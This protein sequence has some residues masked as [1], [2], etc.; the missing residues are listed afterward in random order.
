M[1][2]TNAFHYSLRWLYKSIA[3]L[4][5]TFAVLLS[6]I[7]LFLPYADN[8][9]DEIKHYVN[10]NYNANIEIESLASDWNNTGPTFSGRNISFLSANGTQAFLGEFTIEINLWQSLHQLQLVTQNVKVID[11]TITLDAKIFNKTTHNRK[12]NAL[13][14]RLYNLVLNQ[15]PH[16]IL[17]NS[18]IEIQGESVEH[19]LQIPK[20]SWLNTNTRHQANGEVIVDGLS[21]NTLTLLVDLETDKSNTLSGQAYFEAANINITP[22]IKSFL[23]IEDKQ[24]NS[25]INFKTWLDI[26]ENV[27]TQL[28]VIFGEN[29]LSWQSEQFIQPSSKNTKTT[30]LDNT[31]NQLVVEQGQVVIK[32]LPNNQGY[33]YYTSPILWQVNEQVQQNLEIDGTI[34]KGYVDGYIS[35]IDIHSVSELA[36]LF[37]KS[38]K[39][40]EILTTLSPR[41]VVNE[42]H[43]VLENS[44]RLTTQFHQV[45]I[46]NHQ[47]IPGIENVSGILAFQNK[48]LAINLIATD[49]QLDF[50]EHLKRPVPYEQFSVDMMADVTAGTLVNINDIAFSSPELIFE[51]NVAVSIPEDKSIQLAVL[52]N[53]DELA[54]ES[55]KYYYPYK[56]MKAETLAFL[57]SAITDGKITHGD[58]IFDGY[59]KDFPFNHQKANEA[60]GIF[61]VEAQLENATFKFSPLWPAIQNG[62]AGVNYINDQLSVTAHSG[63]IMGLDASHVTA[64]IK[65]D[66][67]TLDIQMINQEPENVR[68]LMNASTLKSSVG[69]VLDRLMIEHPVSGHLITD[70]PLQGAGATV[71]KGAI[72]FENNRMNLQVPNMTLTDVSGELA[73]TNELLTIEGMTLNWREK[74]VVLDLNAGYENKNYQVNLDFSGSWKDKLWQQEFPD[75][76]QPY[77]HGDFDWQGKLVLYTPKDGDF[78]YEF[79]LESNLQDIELLLPGPFAKKNKERIVFRADIIGN[80]ASSTINFIAKEEVKFRSILSHEAVQLTQTHLALGREHIKLPDDGFYISGDFSDIDVQLWQP[81]ITDFV[82]ALPQKDSNATEPAILPAPSTIGIN[83]DVL[84]VFDEPFNQAIF[85]MTNLNDSW[86]MQLKADKTEGKTKLYPDF[87]TRGL[88]IELDFLTIGDNKVTSVIDDFT[89]EIKPIND[90]A[91]TEKSD[92]ITVTTEKEELPVKESKP[93][94]EIDH[95]LNQTVFNA[96]P[97][98]RLQCQRCIIDGLDFG[99]VNVELTKPDESILK[100]KKLTAKRKGFTGELS[101]HW[102]M[103]DLSSTTQIQGTIDVKSIED[104]MRRIG[105]DSIIKDSGADLTFDINWLGSASDFSLATLNGHIKS[106]LDDGY[107]SKVDDQARI[108]SILSLQ[109]LVRKLTLDFRDVFSDGMFYSEIKGDATIDNGIIYTDNMQMKGAAGDLQVKGNTNLISSQLDYRMSYKPNLTSSLPVLAWVATLNPLAIIAGLAIDEVVTSQVVSEFNFELTGSIDEPDFKEINRENKN[110]S[111]GRSVPPTI[112]ENTTVE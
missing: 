102:A 101:G 60:P 89:Q 79:E 18:Y 29:T 96:I 67:L 16:I 5:V 68:A 25:D 61:V 88:D 30:P 32:A 47:A 77:A 8:F 46:N 105:L 34:N 71:A 28:S 59:L 51:G 43:F 74:P 22:W 31:E 85:T 42:L 75:L 54:G 81:F 12:D 57:E 94:K 92:E 20:L 53:V 110:I 10:T 72:Q 95:Q 82:F 14:D 91:K 73:F 66:L 45:A 112:I 1:K 76:L 6:F 49:G 27:A 70:I 86:L 7:R 21:N 36:S 83:T 106:R 11:S 64:E 37:V 48:Q 41:G 93:K 40:Q 52:M 78:S 63:N 2:T 9:R 87:K 23:A 38:K 13:L 15:I 3:I 103:T 17:V 108:F 44:L 80:V 24:T 100:I 98:I 107:L 104:E 33:R 56:I 111:V 69:N 62:F 35:S 55:L 99:L 4:L 58:I 84:M 65:K 19:T 109:S 26:K 90:V 97:P 39:T 50:G